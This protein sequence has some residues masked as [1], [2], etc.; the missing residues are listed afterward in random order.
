LLIAVLIACRADRSNEVTITPE[1]PKPLASCA[2]LDTYWGHDWPAVI[3]TLDQLTATKQMCGME[4]LASKK[5][6]AHF[7]YGVALEQ[8]RQLEVAIDQYRAALAID[9]QRT[10]ALTALTRLKALPTPTP[11][12]CLAALKPRPDPASTRTPNVVGNVEVREKHLLFDGQPFT[13]KGVNYYPRRAP[14]RQFLVEAKP[15][16]IATE[17]SLIQRAGFN[18]I[19]IFLRYEPL[20]TCAPEDAIPLD[21][22]FAKVDILLELA[23][24]HDLRVIVT[25]NDLPDLYYRP[26][27]TDW[28]HYDAQTI[29]IV[30]RYRNDPNI[31]AWD[32]RNEGD[33]DYSASPGN[34][35]QFSR[36]EVVQ[37]LAHISRLVRANDP[38]HLITAGW[39]GDPTITA[40]YVDILSFHHW[41]VP[42][43]LQA[44][45]TEYQRHNDK[46]LLLEEVGYHSW[47]TAPLDSRDLQSQAGILGRAIDTA[48]QS[49]I[50]GW[51]IW[52]AFDFVPQN[53]QPATYEHFFGLWQTDLTPKP[54]LMTLPLP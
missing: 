9:A 35:P 2:D 53:G 21:P 14:W 31:V 20:F 29:Y 15:E 3:E 37:W 39:W 11:S 49:N 17:L 8:N 27:Y 50:A 47:A 10:E 4:S 40:P 34:E 54:A 45:I 22:V 5:Y 52:T 41:S 18:T 42:E 32:L 6:A 19:R 30:R 24:Q 16:D 23:R 25:L 48:E 13:I 46:P 26:L 1:A 28:A 38:Y 7:N 12:P 44:R 36:D 43:A 51:M 33:L